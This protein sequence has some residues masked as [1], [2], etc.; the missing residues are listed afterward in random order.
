MS[1]SAQPRPPFQRPDWRKA[2]LAALAAAINIALIA[3]LKELVAAKRL[4]DVL[5]ARGLLLVHNANE[6]L[7]L[8]TCAHGNAQYYG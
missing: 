3:A 6:L 2:G 5:P 8:Q 7:E 4:L 1:V